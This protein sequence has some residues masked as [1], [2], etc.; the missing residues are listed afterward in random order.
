[1][2]PI[3]PSATSVG[4]DGAACADTI[5]TT[6]RITR[7]KSQYCNPHVP[8]CTDLV[9]EGAHDSEK[10]IAEFVSRL[11]KRRLED[12]CGRSRRSE[13][14]ADYINAN[15]LRY[16]AHQT[17]R[18][19]QMMR[20]K[21]SMCSQ[22]ELALFQEL[23]ETTQ[24]RH[25]IAENVLKQ[26]KQ[27]EVAEA[28]HNK[29][30]QDHLLTLLEERQQQCTRDVELG[31]QRY[32]AMLVERQMI[33]QKEVVDECRQIVE[34]ILALTEAVAEFT[35]N[36]KI[37]GI[38]VDFQGEPGSDM[39]RRTDDNM[40]FASN[41]ADAEEPVAA[42]A[43]PEVLTP[44]DV[45]P[46]SV[47]LLMKWAV[48]YS[49]PESTDERGTPPQELQ[50]YLLS[51]YLSFV[52]IVS[53]HD[54]GFVMLPDED[55]TDRTSLNVT[56]TSP[57]TQLEAFQ[58]IDKETYRFESLVA[59]FLLEL[60]PSYTPIE[61][62]H[63]EAAFQVQNTANS[64]LQ[65]LPS[66][67]IDGKTFVVVSGPT[68]SGKST[69]IE[70]LAKTHHLEYV[71]DKK[72]INNI[73][74]EIEILV[75]DDGVEIDD[76]RV[77]EQNY[78]DET[79]NLSQQIQELLLEGCALP[80]PLLTRLILWQVQYF[81]L[82]KRDDYSGIIFE[83]STAW[84]V[85]VLDEVDSALSRVA[86]P[87]RLLVPTLACEISDLNVDSRTD[88][89]EPCYLFNTDTANAFSTYF[90]SGDDDRTPEIISAKSRPPLPN[91][92]L[93]PIKGSNVNPLN[94]TILNPF[95]KRS[96]SVELQKSPPT[97]PICDSNNNLMV[98]F[99]SPMNVDKNRKTSKRAKSADPDSNQPVESAES[100]QELAETFQKESV[101]CPDPLPRWTLDEL[102]V[103]KKAK[104]SSH[105][106]LS[107][108]IRLECCPIEILRRCHGRIRKVGSDTAEAVEFNLLSNPPPLD[109]L[110]E[111]F[112]SES[113]CEIQ[114]DAI[115][116]QTKIAAEADQWR[117]ICEWIRSKR[118]QKE[119]HEAL[120][121]GSLLY[122][123]PDIFSI[124][125]DP[126]GCTKN[127]REELCNRIDSI[128]L[129][130]IAKTRVRH[131][132]QL[133]ADNIVARKQKLL[134]MGQ[135]QLV[136]H[137]AEA[138]KLETYASKGAAQKDILTLVSQAQLQST[139]IK[140]RHSPSLVPS[141]CLKLLDMFTQHY[142]EC[143]AK[144]QSQ[145]SVMFCSLFNEGVQATAI[146]E[147]TFSVTP[148]SEAQNSSLQQR[149]IV[150][151]IKDFNA[152]PKRLRCAVCGK[153]ELH[154]RCDALHKNLIT[155][156]EKFQTERLEHIEA[157]TGPSA[158]LDN[159]LTGIAVL[160]SIL[161]QL[162]VER[163]VTVRQVVMHYFTVMQ[164]SH[165]VMSNLL[166]NHDVNALDGL[167]T[168]AVDPLL[169]IS[170][171][172]RE[173]V[174]KAHVEKGKKTKGSSSPP[175]KD[176]DTEKTERNS[177]K[178]KGAA[179]KLNATVRASPSSDS[180]AYFS[181][182]A[183]K[184][185]E[186]VT[187]ML[188]ESLA[189]NAPFPEGT[190]SPRRGASRGGTKISKEHQNTQA[191]I[192]MSDPAAIEIAVAIRPII[193]H[194]AE[195]CVQRINGLAHYFSSV[196]SFGADAIVAVRRHMQQAL[197]MRVDDELRSI[198]GFVFTL[199]CAIE[200]EKCIDGDVLQGISVPMTDN[201]ALIEAAT[202][203]GTEEHV[204]ETLSPLCQV[205]QQNS[206]ESKRSNSHDNVNLTS[207]L[208]YGRCQE[209]ISMFQ[210]SAPHYRIHAEDFCRIVEPKDWDI[211]G[212][213]TQA[214]QKNDCLPTSQQ[215]FELFDTLCCGMIDWREF[216]V[217]LLFWL[218]PVVKPSS[219]VSIVD[220]H[221]PK[222][223]RTKLLSMIH[224]MQKKQRCFSAIEVAHT[225]A[226][227]R[228][229]QQYKRGSMNADITS[230][231]T[232]PLMSGPGLG[233]AETSHEHN[234]DDEND[235][236]VP[237]LPTHEVMRNE[238]YI[239][240]PSSVDL[241]QMRT[242]LGD[243]HLQH[244]EFERTDL[245]NE[246]IEDVD[247][248][249][250]YQEVLWHCF[251]ITHGSSAAAV[252]TADGSIVPHSK[253]MLLD[254][255]RLILFLC[256]DEQPL[257]GLQKAIT[258]AAA[259]GDESC[260]LNI[261]QLY[262]VFHHT[263]VNHAECRM[264]DPYGIAHLKQLFPEDLPLGS[265]SE[266]H[267]HGVKTTF[268]HLCSVA[269]GQRLLNENKDFQIRK[270]YTSK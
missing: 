246:M 240:P 100:Y 68:F 53:Q 61:D 46:R 118:T 75:D 84:T 216:I 128:V 41:T 105:V 224:T 44:F 169:F 50:Q 245:L 96:K 25:V 250:C 65:L 251:A 24:W 62:A 225:A 104:S 230:L 191:A 45:V 198:N 149:L 113:T 243:A 108:I 199:R 200:T 14:R 206:D 265:P 239:E 58:D 211:Y 255:N 267:L 36:K 208:T 266:Q 257:R 127:S 159:W 17:E 232:S 164:G 54:G 16:Q 187:S 223:R 32:N 119:G 64:Q 233:H 22:K 130:Q 89:E 221:G 202:Q 3:V 235:E 144:A 71:D 226:D 139:S 212:I 38:Y 121:H 13:R 249:R 28:A 186:R 91:P 160:V 63:T 220:F 87:N 35:H 125:S 181:Q 253:S 77:D 136:E 218:E 129:D 185:V 23:H 40:A 180:M 234:D 188:D 173:E 179:I 143:T 137:E 102:E 148:L 95:P 201:R 9:D 174:E 264:L 193:Q 47:F 43:V 140:P 165:S 162:E 103:I 15:F 237:D 99:S 79:V 219:S 120:V 154:L 6:G 145:L 109:R 228:A 242:E 190:L 83:A 170:Q 101:P 183:K 10:V 52:E 141:V 254:P 1:M 34:K 110:Q 19:T 146:L 56:E 256:A 194:E 269:L 57:K 258:V 8:L 158:F 114:D 147:E 70:Q 126:Q 197:H 227:D 107:C 106:G 236:L 210:S 7:T 172:E 178:G 92:V 167:I 241:F 270:F 217:H 21:L 123:L 132:Q 18:R 111:F 142:A 30:K 222:N 151:F 93:Y 182:C 192:N 117:D 26:K 112:G 115:G 73:L 260:E 33:R 207:C 74:G 131:H 69:V 248:R 215:V 60:L 196:A 138:Q 229:A 134:T 247:R 4:A 66:K 81:G 78:Y 252:A 85:A 97:L 213:H 90:F 5:A 168:S 195:T 122:P 261:T 94:K 155:L 20:A 39:I 88:E 37:K 203:D 163:L 205:S 76:D 176:A 11:K 157:L 82:Q 259:V 175:G 59:N 42:K 55:D 135:T 27:Q 161:I 263:A 262:N 48:L 238:Y 209:I 231:N 72:M 2:P 51:D 184:A 12:E 153:E 152:V 67:L 49:S 177:G 133:E 98:K 29:Q 124:S 80:P 268:A 204:Q 171:L 244:D 156:T 86:T 214:P 150:S 166:V 31:M 116:L 189:L